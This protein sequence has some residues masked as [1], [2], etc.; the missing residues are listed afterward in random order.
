VIINVHA[1]IHP[2]DDVDVKLEHYDHPDLVRT[3]LCGDNAKVKEAFTR[4][5]DKVI[6]L[7]FL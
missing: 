3:C 6:G 7:G 2:T 4:Y 1:H 5:P